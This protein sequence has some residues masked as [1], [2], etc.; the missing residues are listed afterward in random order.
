M[1]YVNTPLVV[2]SAML[3][4]AGIPEASLL[5]PIWCMSFVDYGYTEKG[6]GT[7]ITTSG[8]VRVTRRHNEMQHDATQCAKSCHDQK[9]FDEE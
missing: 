5:V 8:E 6:G 4:Q 2:F 7:T 3:W 9:N 1:R